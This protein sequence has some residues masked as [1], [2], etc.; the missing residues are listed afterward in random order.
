MA[1]HSESGQYKNIAVSLFCSK[2]KIGHSLS[3]IA[4]PYGLFLVVKAP[5]GTRPKESEAGVYDSNECNE[6]PTSSIQY[7]CHFFNI[8]SVDDYYKKEEKDKI[9]IGKIICGRIIF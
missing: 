4:S 3:L 2:M 9:L 8:K 7:G 5:L 6:W 1:R